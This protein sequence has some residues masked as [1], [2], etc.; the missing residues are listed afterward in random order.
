MLATGG[1]IGLLIFGVIVLG[2]YSI[3]LIKENANLRDKNLNLRIEN[4]RHNSDV[5][6]EALN[7]AVKNNETKIN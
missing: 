1:A 2:C 6:V 3:L 5:I 7:K 4:M